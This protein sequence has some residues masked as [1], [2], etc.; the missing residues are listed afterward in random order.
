MQQIEHLHSILEVLYLLIFL[1]NLL[2]PEFFQLSFP[3]F[4]L[5][6]FISFLGLLRRHVLPILVEVDDDRLHVPSPFSKPLD[7]PL[8]AHYNLQMKIVYKF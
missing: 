6:C 5:G 7:V 8:I 1:C 4:R 3:F 2:L